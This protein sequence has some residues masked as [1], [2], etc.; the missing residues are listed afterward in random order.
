VRYLSYA[1]I[2]DH[3]TTIV[4]AGQLWHMQCAVLSTSEKKEHMAASAVEKKQQL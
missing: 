4:K 1:T 2:A 3:N